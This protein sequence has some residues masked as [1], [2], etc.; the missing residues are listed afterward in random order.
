MLLPVP[1]TLLVDSA[2][3]VQTNVATKNL[4]FFYNLKEHQQKNKLQKNKF[5]HDAGNTQEVI[6]LCNR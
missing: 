3:P 6:I 5:V 2:W 1:F 4:V